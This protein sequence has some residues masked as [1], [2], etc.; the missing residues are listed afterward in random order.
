MAFQK[1][2]FIVPILVVSVYAA[3]PK[4]E[5]Y[6]KI[7]CLGCRQFEYYVLDVLFEIGFF[8]GVNAELEMISSS[9]VF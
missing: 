8:Y 9:N 6:C 2:Y 3:L 5:L 7:L 1:L 4:V